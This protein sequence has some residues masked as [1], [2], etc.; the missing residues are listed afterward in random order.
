MGTH[1]WLQLSWPRFS[2]KIT[3]EMHHG[4]G[5]SVSIQICT[6]CNVHIMLKKQPPSLDP[7]K[8][9]PWFFFPWGGRSH[10]TRIWTS[11]Y[12]ECICSSYVLKDKL[13]ANVQW[14]NAVCEL[15]GCCSSAP[16]FYSVAL[17]GESK[18]CLEIILAIQWLTVEFAG[19]FATVFAALW[20]SCEQQPSLISQLFGEDVQK[21]KKKRKKKR[22]PFSPTLPLGVFGE[23]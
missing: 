22:H 16:D 23:G 7:G 12:I 18:W 15:S 10:W 13:G 1:I 2:P 6:C 20:R 11:V 8:A 19:W 14:I 17:P 21:K 5:S 4:P 9:R 3:E